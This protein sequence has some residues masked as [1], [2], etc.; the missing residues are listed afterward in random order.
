MK[1]WRPDLAAA[2][3]LPLA[4]QW[5]L[6]CD[7]HFIGALEGR[8]TSLDGR[9][10]A[11]IAQRYGIS[12]T[13]GGERYGKLGKLLAGLNLTQGMSLVERAE[14]TAAALCAWEGRTVFSAASKISWFL[15]P[16][17]WTMFDTYAC[18]TVCP[19]G[20]SAKAKFTDFYRLLDDAGFRSTTAEVRTRLPAEMNSNLAERVVDIFVMLTS[21]RAID[22]KVAAGELFVMALPLPLRSVV[23]HAAISVAPHLEKFGCHFQRKAT[24]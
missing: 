17:D 7:A 21:D 15:W 12:R 2:A 6:S 10:V 3:A 8:P 18:A 1:P 5:W 19:E 13:L 22:R 24:H 11:E 20:S 23:Q 9:W 14:A 16:T 4:Y